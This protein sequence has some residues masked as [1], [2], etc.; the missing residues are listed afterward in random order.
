MTRNET[1]QCC[2]LEVLATWVAK[3][4]LFFCFVG[5]AIIEF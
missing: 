5:H 2:H 3:R 1:T 4:E